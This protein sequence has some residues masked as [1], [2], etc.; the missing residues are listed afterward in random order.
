MLKREEQKRAI[1]NSKK[2]TRCT[3]LSVG[4][5]VLEELTTI[6]ID[7]C[8]PNVKIRTPKFAYT[9]FDLEIQ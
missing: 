4:V 5:R 8:E 6:D 2:K 9:S 7:Y 3:E 1:K